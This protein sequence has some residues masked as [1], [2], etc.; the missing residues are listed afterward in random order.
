MHEGKVQ[1][2]WRI[3]KGQVTI[4]ARG[5][6]QD[7]SSMYSFEEI[8]AQVA[9]L[10]SVMTTATIAAKEGRYNRKVDIAEAYLNATI[11]NKIILIRIEPALVDIILM[12]HPEYA[13]Y[14]QPDGSVDGVAACTAAY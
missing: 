11:K 3:G 13:M 1:C 8:S 10:T 2:V 6:R 7:R 14:R 12:E 5:D 4:S 9:T